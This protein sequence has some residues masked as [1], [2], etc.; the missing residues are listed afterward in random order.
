MPFTL[1]HPAAVLPFVR[2]RFVTAGLVAGAMAPD[3]PYFARAA[4]IPVYAGAW[5]EPFLNATT[6]HSWPGA[7]TVSLVYA[8]ALC[9]C[10]RLVHP[11]LLDLA[12]VQI[13]AG[14]SPTC[15]RS[16]LVGLGWLVASAL[17]GIASHLVWDAIT[18]A[19]GSVVPGAGLLRAPM[20]GE[21]SWARA[22]RHVSSVVGLL[23]VA[24]Y[25]AR[26]LRG[27]PRRRLGACR[28]WTLAV[29]AGLVLAAGLVTGWRATAYAGGRSADRAAELVLSQAA[30]GAGAAA[31][32][33]VLL[34]AAAW[35]T[36]QARAAPRSR[37]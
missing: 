14:R 1:A 20:V 9:G 17:V 35:W 12:P 11:P 2:G 37:P 34:Y 4:R 7:V 26:R 32:A 25:V 29:G 21:L 30:K 33:A 23:V 18:H 31:I 5:H 19:N 3:M 13:P 22:L 28:V 16:P 15:A 6:S 10:Y 24:V 36:T 27:M 8:L